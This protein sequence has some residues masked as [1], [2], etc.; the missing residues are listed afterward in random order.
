VC[1]AVLTGV[2]VFVAVGVKVCVA[3]GVG[4]QL[5]GRCTVTVSVSLTFGG[6]VAETVRVADGWDAG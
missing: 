2:E 6:Q 3:V 4:R 1:V 5:P